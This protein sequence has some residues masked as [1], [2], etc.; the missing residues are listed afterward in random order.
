MKVKIYTLP[1]CHFCHEE[2]AFLKNHNIDFVEINLENN[3]EAQDEMI[4]VSGQMG[5]PVTVIDSTTIAGFNR[6]V[7]AKKLGIK[8]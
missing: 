7:L 4:R 6:E 8:E 1:S 3:R 5:V 2:K